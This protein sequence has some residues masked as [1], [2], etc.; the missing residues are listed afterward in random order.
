MPAQKAARRLHLTEAEFRE[1]LY[2]LQRAGFPSACSITGHYDLKAID[3]WLD[4]RAGLGESTGAARNAAD[5]F[6]ERR[7]KR[8]P[9]VGLKERM[10][11]MLNGPASPAPNSPEPWKPRQYAPGEI[12]ELIRSRPM[13]KT[14][15]IALGGFYAVRDQPSAIVKGCGPSKVERLVARG[16]IKV[17]GHSNEAFIDTCKIT[18]EGEAAW[19]AIANREA[20]D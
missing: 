6:E 19:L 11:A 2:A 17:V 15:K 13:T 4:R 18:P 14:E 3:A 7:A 9:R 20:I 1:K 5:V 16:F 8:D 10:D 12:E